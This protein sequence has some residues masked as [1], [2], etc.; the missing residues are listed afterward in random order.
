MKLPFRIGTRGSLLA[1]WQANFVKDLLL[2][3]C[4]ELKPQIIEIKTTGDM[5]LNSPLSEIGG[6]GLFV[7]EI[8]EVLLTEAVDIAVHSMKDLPAFLPD[9]LIIGS[10]AE[11]H[12]P[13]DAL[14]SNGGL[15]L[16][17][18]PEGARV[19]TGSLRRGAQL[20]NLMP[21]LRIK[22]IRGNVD[23]RLRKLRVGEEFEAIVLAAAGLG[24]MGLIGEAAEIIP[25]D[26][27]VPAPG[28]GIIAVECREGDT[29]TLDIIS[30]INHPETWTAGIAERAFL[31]R[32]GGDCNIPVGCYAETDGKFLKAA[33]VIASPDGRVVIRE[34]SVGPAVEA[35]S[36]GRGIAE[37]LL[38]KGGDGLLAAL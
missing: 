36:L 32:I 6:K 16:S 8:E 25:A 2:S 37:L 12:D 26:V 15:M 38:D 19:G 22:P 10:V 18:L 30:K 33:C 4:P 21:E 17:Q 13:R 35:E 31:K 11:R 14:V 1:L 23:T 9:G 34:N 24:R 3:A 5:N 29:E 27:I 7:K 20:L 28:Q